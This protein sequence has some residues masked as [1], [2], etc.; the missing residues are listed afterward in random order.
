MFL[1]AAVCRRSVCD[2]PLYNVLILSCS[3][4]AEFAGVGHVAR[5]IEVKS[6]VQCMPWIS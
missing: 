3:C 5:M 4:V 2:H 1:N 6:S